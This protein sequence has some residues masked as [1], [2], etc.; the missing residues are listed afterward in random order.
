MI[1]A[2]Y[3]LLDDELA[4]LYIGKTVQLEARLFAHWRADRVPFTRVVWRQVHE[5]AMTVLEAYLIG[6]INPPCN[7]KFCG[8]MERAHRQVADRVLSRRAS[9]FPQP[10]GRARHNLESDP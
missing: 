3:F 4:I 1:S 9:E 2:V 7:R 8:A 10:A 6:E 5:P